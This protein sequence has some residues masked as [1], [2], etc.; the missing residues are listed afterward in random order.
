MLNKLI[1]KRGRVFIQKT[2][3]L[4]I[5]LRFIVILAF[6][7]FLS[8]LVLYFFASNE[9]E[10]KLYQAHMNIINTLDILFPLIVIT[11]LTVFLLL[12]IITIYTVLYL[13]HRIAGPLYKFERIAE[14]IES[15]NLNV[16]VHLRQKD[17][18]LPLKTAFEKMLDNLRDKIGNL[19]TSYKKIKVIDEKL[20]AVIR[21]S[22]IPETEKD[23]L[24]SEL[25]EFMAIYEKNI[26]AFTLE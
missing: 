11:S 20:H 10:T 2:F 23:S 5:I 17:E 22:A 4:K 18:L 16:K 26:D 6:G 3:Q 14:E 24:A 19:K 15:G 9:L 1:R 13:S 25:K 12:S 8:G 7:G 21:D